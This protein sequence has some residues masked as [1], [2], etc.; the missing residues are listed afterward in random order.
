MFKRMLATTCLAVGLA[1][2]SAAAF[3][4]ECGNVVI[5]NMD[6]Q[7]VDVLANIDKI[8][9][10]N[11][12]GCSAEIT[13]GDTVSIMTSMVEKGEP[14]IAPEVWLNALPDIVA[15]GVS[16]GKLISAGNALSD[17]GMQGW[18][19]PKYIADAH[20][21]IRKVSDALKHPELF[22]APED[23][24]KGAVFNGPA[25]WGASTATNQLYKA[26]E[27]DAKG[28]M[29]VDPGSA[30]GLDGSIAKNYERQIGWLGYYWSPSSVLGKYSMV[31][32]DSDTPHDAAEW[33]RCI[34]V[35]D[36]ADPK[37]N[38]WPVDKVETLV[39][40]KFAER[41]GVAMDYLKARRWDNATVNEILAWMTENQATGE[42]AAKYF[43]KNKPEIWTKWLSPEVADKVKAWL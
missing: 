15:R 23:N 40:G 28:F 32:L 9:L 37:V 16:E 31:K 5:A 36:C 7:S 33:K 19:I 24:S 12:Y 3:A 39:T 11:G 43:L 21:D 10:E 30:A 38:A 14:D 13:I 27:G 1:S 20:P 17:G 8:I 26:Y 2:L 34:T 42:E 29:L 35:A 6:W 22:P 41:A 25:G 4:A 18:Y